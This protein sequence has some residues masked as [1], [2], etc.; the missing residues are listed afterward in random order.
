MTKAPSCVLAGA[1]LLVLG[2][3][4]CGGATTRPVQVAVLIGLGLLWLLAP[5]RRIP[6]HGFVICAGGLLLLA[7]TAWLPANWFAAESWRPGL[8]AVGIPLGPT[9]SPQLW[10]SAEA[11]LWLVMGLAWLGWLLGRPWTGIDADLDGSVAGGRHRFARGFC[12]RGAGVSF[13]RARLASRS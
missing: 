13:L 3:I 7:A 6:D 4:A 10:L 12:S 9:L 5:A 11:G 2:A 8:L 1:A